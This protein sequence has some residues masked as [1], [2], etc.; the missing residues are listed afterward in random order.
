MIFQQQ[1]VPGQ[2]LIYRELAKMLNMSSTPVQ[3]ALGR[4]EQE[5]FVERIPNVGYYVR[6]INL[7]EIEDLF[8]LRLILELYAVELAIANQTPEDI[9]LL[10]KLLQDHKNYNIQIY[11]RRKL[12]LDAAFHSQIAGLS[13]NLEIVK[14]LRRIFEHTYLRS[15]VELI[16]PG[17]LPIAASEHEQI[18]QKI[19]E[20]DVVRAREYLERHIR[21][22]KEARRAML[23]ALPSMNMSAADM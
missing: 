14:Q 2:K 15:P 19:K 5:G 18:L 20:R 23:A 10:E 6:K 3:F 11:D 16:P 7:Q 1:I 13:R 4:L 8:D 17:R 21:E 22:A 12:I 9:R